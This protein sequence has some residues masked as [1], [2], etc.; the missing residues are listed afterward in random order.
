MYNKADL[1]CLLLQLDPLRNYASVAV[2]VGVSREYVRQIALAHLHETAADR[3]RR[4]KA[5]APIK[6][7]KAKLRRE[8]IE[9]LEKAGYGYCSTSSHVGGRVV[10]YAIKYSRCR[11][12]N[13]E[14]MYKHLGSE[15]GAETLRRYK[16]SEA[17]KAMQA[18]SAKKWQARNK[19]KRLEYQR[20]YMEKVR[21]TPEGMQ[22]LRD[23]WHRNSR[24]YH[25]KKK[26]LTDVE[27]EKEG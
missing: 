12:C 1:V 16:A 8:F 2:E 10:D 11:A 24:K 21:S 25:H 19:E 14:N 26:G 15:R 4:R 3:K 22:K 13:L 5:A 17:G 27:H 20:R 23:M 6:W 9:I 7:S 18:K